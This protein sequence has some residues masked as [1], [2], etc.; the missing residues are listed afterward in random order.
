MS[1]EKSKQEEVPAEVTEETTTQ[2]EAS[3]EE[4]SEKTDDTYY[5][6]KIK[7]LETQVTKRTEEKEN[8]LKALQQERTKRRADKE[9]GETAQPEA[10]IDEDKIAAM[11]NKHADERYNEMRV[12]MATSIF[13]EELEHLTV[14][15]KE[16]AL[17][18]MHY[19]SSIK[20]SGFD[21]ASIRKDLLL[22]KA[23]ANIDRVK[24][25]TDKGDIALST[26]MAGGSGKS[27][28]LA[29]EPSIDL[30]P[31]EEKLLKRFGVSPEEAAKSLAAK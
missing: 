10:T 14:N 24:L 22:S 11:V 31:A 19:R 5:E 21:R 18:K 6:E 4:T 15:D 25:T 8:L 3:A 1:E 23:A 29:S 13:D 30:N 17:I 7:E 9:E 28:D 27:R 16:R 2:P 20:P 26:A 12:D